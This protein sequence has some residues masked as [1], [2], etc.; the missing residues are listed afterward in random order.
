MIERTKAMD[1]L[2]LTYK[3]RLADLMWAVKQYNLED[4]PDVKALKV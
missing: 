2:N 3:I 1:Q 4:D